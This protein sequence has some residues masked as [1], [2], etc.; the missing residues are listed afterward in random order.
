MSL[1]RFPVR[2][3]RTVA[4]DIPGVLDVL[5][6]R[7]SG[8]LVSSLNK[9]MFAFAG[10]EPVPDELVDKSRLQKAMLFELSMARAESLLS[11]DREPSWDH[12]LQLASTRQRRHY[13][14]K[15]P[16]K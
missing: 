8:G 3:P 14:A 4:R 16:D 15:V 5:F 6:P 10:V 9:K 7:L 13:D 2:D 12:C 11:G 1:S